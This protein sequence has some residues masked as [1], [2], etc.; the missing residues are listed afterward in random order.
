MTV[1][2]FMDLAL[3]DPAARLLRPRRPTIGP[4]GRF[5]Y[6]RRRRPAV[7]RAARAAARRNGPASSR[8]FRI[9]NSEF[10]IRAASIWSKP[11]PA[12]AGCRRTSCARSN[13]RIPICYARTRLHLVE[14][15]DAARQAQRA[16]LADHRRSIGLVLRPRAAVR[17]RADR[18]RAARCDAGA[19]GG[20]ASAGIARG[21]CRCRP[22][23]NVRLEDC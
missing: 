13:P 19:S 10:R 3:Y 12:T 4:R 5:F 6:Q 7:R 23:A 8:E 16:T 22:F 21:L 20:D 15:S 11:A 2:A 18:Q 1:A 17:G 14:A 9:Q